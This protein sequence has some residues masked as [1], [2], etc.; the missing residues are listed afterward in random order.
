MHWEQ[1]LLEA[2]DT[3]GGEVILTVC[4]SNQEAEEQNKQLFDQSNHIEMHPSHTDFEISGGRDKVNNK[5]QNVGL[6]S[7]PS[8][9][10]TLGST[11]L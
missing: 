5:P 1:V 9:T 2:R 3:V 7:G 4:I 10:E 6:S 11:Y 8:G